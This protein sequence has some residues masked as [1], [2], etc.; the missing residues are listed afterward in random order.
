MESLQTQK[1]LFKSPLFLLLLITLFGAIV[2]IW[3]FW[4]DPPH[5]DE[6]YTLNLMQNS[7]VEIVRFSLTND[8]NPPLFYLID[9]V[10]TQMF[11]INMFAERLPSVIFGIL[12]I[13][14]AYKLGLEYK[15]ETLGLLS[16]LAV[17]TLGSMWYYSQFGRAYMLECLLF[18]VAMV[19][20][21]RL[22]RGDSR[23]YHWA[24]FAILSAV[25]AFTHLFSVIPL[26]F[27]WVY[28]IWLYAFDAIK[29]AVVTFV[30]ASPL[31][32]LFY[33]IFTS[34]MA[35]R[36]GMWYGP[37]LSHLIIFAP[38]EFFG[39]VFM[40][41][42]GL[43]AFSIYLY[44]WK[45]REVSVIIVTSILSYATLLSICNITP[46]FIR[47]ILLMVPAWVVIG[48]LPVS[49]FVDSEDATHAQKWF[50]V[51]SFALC[52]FIIIAFSIYSGLYRPK[53]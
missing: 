13:P 44:W 40:F 20:Y 4:T 28:L 41:W 50:V 23:T 33:A 19:Y 31:L 38:L 32:L 47:Y 39:Y 2:R 21:V 53:G 18:T 42:I 30:L 10:S 8:C 43:I 29:W 17:S 45:M 26:T 15:G 25:L 36:M 51:G 12:L 34:R 46:V 52:Y 9:W 37:P 16:A 24:A 7:W 48:L 11:G 27:L 22:I 35:G 49:Q 6:T 14:A 3:S 5:L 1:T